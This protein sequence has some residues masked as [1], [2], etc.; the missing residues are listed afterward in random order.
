[1]GPLLVSGYSSIGMMNSVNRLSRNTLTGCQVR[2][3]AKK[4]AAG[5]RNQFG[6][7]STLSDVVDT[8]QSRPGIAIHVAT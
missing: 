2:P 3:T 7:A 8:F 6:D 4:W 1:M 5:N